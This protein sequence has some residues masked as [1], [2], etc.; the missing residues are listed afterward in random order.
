[1]CM[2]AIYQH[3]GENDRARRDEYLLDLDQ[4]AACFQP[5]DLSSDFPLGSRKFS[6]HY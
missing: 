2:M 3:K 5:S 4:V 1:M 6:S